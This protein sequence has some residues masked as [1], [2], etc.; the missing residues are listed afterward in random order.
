MAAG[1][2]DLVPQ[3]RGLRTETA[4]DAVEAELVDQEQ[5]EPGVEANAVV[6]GLVGQSRSQI[7][8]SSK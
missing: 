1:V 5:V 3:A 6:D 7:L 8:Q 4:F 2:D